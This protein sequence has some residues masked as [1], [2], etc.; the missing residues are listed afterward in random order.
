MYNPTINDVIGI[1]LPIVKGPS[2]LVM[3]LEQLFDP[4]LRSGSK[5]FSR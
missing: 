4:G 2:S 1:K 3:K 5:N